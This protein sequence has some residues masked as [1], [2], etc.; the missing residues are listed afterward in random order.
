[1]KSLTSELQTPG[2][3]MFLVESIQVNICVMQFQ[4]I[5]VWNKELIYCRCVSTLP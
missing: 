1:M 5:M 3:K 4:F 2:R